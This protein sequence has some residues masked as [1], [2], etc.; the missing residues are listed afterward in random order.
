MARFAENAQDNWDRTECLPSCTH[1]SHQHSYLL[2]LVTN[3]RSQRQKHKDKNTKTNTKTKTQKWQKHNITVSRVEG[4]SALISHC[5]PCA[6]PPPQPSSGMCPHQ[7][8][9]VTMNVFIC[10]Q[11][12]VQLICM[13]GPVPPVS[14]LAAHLRNGS[15]SVEALA[16]SEWGLFILG[17][18]YAKRQQWPWFGKGGLD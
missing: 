9:S 16:R 3:Q 15:R 14:S 10:C 13:C 11:L 17:G 5:P 7:L 12:N 2:E 4:C 6:Q 1:H 8:A 18:N